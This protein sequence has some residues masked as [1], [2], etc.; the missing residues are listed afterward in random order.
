MGGGRA[1]VCKENLKFEGFKM[2]KWRPEQYSVLCGVQQAERVGWRGNKTRDHFL[3]GSKCK[4]TRKKVGYWTMGI[5][6]AG[7]A[8]GSA[9]VG[10]GVLIIN[11]TDIDP[12]IF[13]DLYYA[14]IPCEN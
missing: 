10:G 14:V 4:T 2:A 11:N 12:S 7:E 5:R 9:A 3:L 8:G 6:E 1:E 13:Q